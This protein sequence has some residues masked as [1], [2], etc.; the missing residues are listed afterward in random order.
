MLN[1]GLFLVWLAA[2]TLPA[3]ALS[4]GLVGPLQALLAMLPQLFAVLIGLCG[5]LL[6]MSYWR[7]RLRLHARGLALLLLLALTLAGL[8]VWHGSE[9]R[10]GVLATPTPA[11]TLVVTNQEWI[12]FRGD[13]G[14]GGLGVV[15]R[16]P[17]VARPPMVWSH[18]DPDGSQYLSSPV[19][20]LGRVYVGGTHF[21][22]TRSA[23]SID[24][25]DANDGHLIWRTLTRHGVFA[26]PIVAAGR[27]YCGEGFH[28][29]ED[30]QLHCLDAN[31]GALIYTVATRG[32]VEGAPTLCG[33]R[34][35]FASGGDG[36]R[37]IQADSGKLLWH[38][39]CGHC[40]S[41]L[42]S[43]DGRLYLGTAYADDSAVCLD[44]NNGKT[45]W[46]KPQDLPV[47]GHPALAGRRVFFGLG[48]GTFGGGAPH[49]RGAVI[50]LDAQRG[51]QLWRTKLGD[52]V[53][54]SLCVVGS[55]L[56]F[57]SRDGF[58]YCLSQSDGKLQWKAFCGNPVLASLV[59]QGDT[60]LALGGDGCLHALDRDNG[61][62]RWKMLV[63]DVPCESSPILAG[64]RLFL[65]AGT[66]LQCLG[67]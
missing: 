28:Q 31:T 46:S 10:S 15:D 7:Q 33:Q 35:V 26:S 44:L 14:G 12:S 51:Q 21:T 30:A 22:A 47:W 18:S 19:V 13:V 65:G 11:T 2:L 56:L 39:R 23:G 58:V 27:V 42:A 3:H 45:L 37:C 16:L 32:H 24:C 49:P 48:N 34:L 4:P 66:S 50:C 52:S 25:L 62:H 67:K 6:S 61:E 64:G 29:D 43:G 57:G 40:D 5:S 9:R 38:S 63:S 60:V 20:A 55:Q 17:L 1:S 41:S 53:N 59:I 36:V 8:L 54:T